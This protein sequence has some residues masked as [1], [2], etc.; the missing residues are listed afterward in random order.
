MGYFSN[1]TEG[2]MYEEEY[3]HR[4]VHNHPEHGC[5]C[6]EAHKWWNYDEC[7]KPES[8]LHKMIPFEKEKR[9]GVHWPDQCI[10]FVEDVEK[11]EIDLSKYKDKAKDIKQW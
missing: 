11:H 1:G 8:I 7:N 6:W 10:F 3:C 9:H 4:C 2:D 5:P